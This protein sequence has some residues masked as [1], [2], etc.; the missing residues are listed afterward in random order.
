MII[1]LLAACL[2]QNPEAAQNQQTMDAMVQIRL[3][4]TV[5]PAQILTRVALDGP[6]ADLWN[7][8]AGSFMFAAK[9]IQA[10][11]FYQR[12]LEL[13]PENQ[14]AKAGVKEA[15]E[16]IDFLNQRIDHFVDKAETE[17]DFKSRCSQAAIIFHLGEPVEAIEI[18]KRALDEYNGEEEVRGLLTTLSQG[19][20]IDRL[21][22]DKLF[23]QFNQGM[24]ENKK[25][26]AVK[27][28]SQI[29]VISLGLLKTEPLIEKL[30]TAFPEQLDKAR[31]AT[32]LQPLVGLKR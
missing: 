19:M 14:D 7:E 18:L 8:L 13:D 32:A 31:L 17:K 28:L 4:E 1:L 20:I 23:K 2:A 27:S 15:G 29:Y 10:K 30:T 16:R 3:D 11:H 5:E 21:A 6:A 24:E 12:A 25:E 9:P 26:Q 22:M